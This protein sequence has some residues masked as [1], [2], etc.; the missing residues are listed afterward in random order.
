M[1][2]KLTWFPLYVDDWLNSRK[3]RRMDAG[4]V[5]IYILLLCEQWQGGPL[6]DDDGDLMFLARAEIEDIREVLEQCFTKTDGRWANERLT[7]IHAEQIKKHDRR[8]E[9]GRKGGEATAE[10]RSSNA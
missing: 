2:E 8:V 9:A 4:Y 1:S 6:P 10:Q 3:V 7:E 5:G